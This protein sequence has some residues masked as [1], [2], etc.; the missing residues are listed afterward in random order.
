AV[1]VAGGSEQAMLRE[2]LRDMLDV[3]VHSF[4]PF[5]GLER[6]D[7]PHV[8]RGAFAG[9]IGL[10]HA[11]ADS[12]ELPI[13]FVKPREPKPVKDPNQ[14]KI[15]LGVGLAA[16]LLVAAVVYCYVQFSALDRQ[17]VAQVRRDAELKSMLDSLE[18]DAA[19]FKALS[20]WD[21]RGVVTL[22]ELYDT[23]LWLPDPSRIQL[24]NFAITPGP[25]A[26]DKHVAR[27]TLEGIMAGDATLG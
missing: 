25:D 11:F 22:D 24:L 10:L 18:V 12:A 4:D 16:S 9:A 23:A 17:V 26:K 15:L 19:K 7:L 8:G 6:P 21:R 27:I 13:N 14:R 5:A 1:Y 2:R 3:P 20:D